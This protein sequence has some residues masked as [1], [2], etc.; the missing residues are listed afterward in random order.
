VPAWSFVRKAFFARRS[1]ACL[2]RHP[3]QASRV[4]GGAAR[5]ALLDAS[6]RLIGSD[7]HECPICGW[8]GRSF[9]TFLSPDEVIPRCICPGC[10]SF[11]R[12]RFL[13]LALEEELRRRDGIRPGALLGF[14]LSPSLRFWLEREGLPRC[15]RT[16]VAVHEARFA[17]DFLSDLRRTAVIEA[18]I[19]WIFCSHVLEHIAELNLCLDEMARLLAPGGIAW[20]QVPLEPD[21]ERSQRLEIDPHRAHAHAWRFGRDFGR[22]LARDDWGIKEITAGAGLPRPLTE[23]LGIDPRERLWRLRKA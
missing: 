1:P 13:V 10:R 4:A 7:R 8:R 18:S 15:W 5:N 6:E 14:S 21:L 2:W 16:D 17:P 9:R 3:L 12:H 19:D 23:R 11:D 20:I 22:L